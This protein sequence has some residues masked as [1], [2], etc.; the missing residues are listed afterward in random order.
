MVIQWTTDLH[1]HAYHELLQS[2]E[3]KLWRTKLAWDIAREID[4]DLIFFDDVSL[5][6]DTLTVP[7]PR[8]KQRDFV[9]QPLLDIEKNTTYEQL[10][11]QSEST[12]INRFPRVE[13][14]A[15]IVGILNISP[16]SF[17]DGQQRTKET[18]HERILEL[19]HHGADII[20][21]WA[22]STAPGSQEIT[23]EVELER[24]EIFFLC[25]EEHI[26][27]VAFSLDT[28]KA[29]VARIGIQHWIQYINDVSGWR[30]DPYMYACI[31][32]HPEVKYICMYAKNNSW[33]ADVETTTYVDIVDTIH[34]FF[35][36][37]IQLMQERWIKLSQIIL[38]PWMWA[39]VS[40]SAQD[41]VDILQHIWNFKKKHQLPLFVWSSRKW[42][43]KTLSPDSWPISRVWSSVASS[44][45]AIT[46]WATYIRVHDVLAMKQCMDVMIYLEH[47]Q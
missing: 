15:K 28:T 27:P 1:I 2:I 10:L 39:F 36:E 6:T 20:D 40:S 14:T 35:H 25:I 30:Q 45:Y 3:Q 42:F 44:W 43:L 32:S 34:T 17:S 8:R 46:Q 4:L 5:D 12:I 41:S 9:L 38:D 47:N 7:H 22:E 23:K 18:L 13:H 21:V 11:E 16:D 33:R 26:Y 19:V 37:R 31:A 24:L 29:E